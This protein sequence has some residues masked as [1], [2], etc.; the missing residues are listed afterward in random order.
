MKENLGGYLRRHRESCGFGL[1][2]LAGLVGISP[3]YLSRIETGRELS[4]SETALKGLAAQLGLEADFLCWL[5][6]RMPSDVEAWLLAD[7]ARLGWVRSAI[8]RSR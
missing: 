6:Q 8:R 4:P 7:P 2:E 3:T 1:R 5:A